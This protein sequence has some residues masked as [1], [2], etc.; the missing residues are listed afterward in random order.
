MESTFSGLD[1][2]EYEGQHVNTVM[3]ESMGRDLCRGILLQQNL[4]VPKE[5][6]G[7]LFKSIKPKTFSAEC[8]YG[9]P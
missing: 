6:K 4:A 9:D 8:D 2:G 7:M 1:Q 3:L 5:L